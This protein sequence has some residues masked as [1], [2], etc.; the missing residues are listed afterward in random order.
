MSLQMP[1]T[2]LPITAEGPI[3]KGMTVPQELIDELS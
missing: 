3:P 1:E 2:L